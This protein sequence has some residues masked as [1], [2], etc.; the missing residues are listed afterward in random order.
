MDAPGLMRKTDPVLLVDSNAEEILQWHSAFNKAGISNPLDV[1]GNGMEAVAYLSRQNQA[2][3]PV[4]VLLN[5]ATVDAFEVL[6]WCQD[7]HVQ[8]LPIIVLTSVANQSEIQKAL[9][10]G[11]TDYRFQP[12]DLESMILL[13]QELRFK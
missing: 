6:R 12:T 11:A 5:L 13:A 8:D 10:L 3:R 9:N 2:S 4:L 1:V 7:H